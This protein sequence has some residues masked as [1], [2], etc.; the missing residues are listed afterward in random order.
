G[1]D[2]GVAGSI[3]QDALQG[4]VVLG[5]RRDVM[6]SLLGQSPLHGLKQLAVDQWRLRARA[7]L[8]FIENLADVEAIAQEVEQGALRE[9]HAT[10]R[11]AVRQLADLCSPIALAK[12]E[13]QPVDAAE[14]EIATKDH[15]DPLGLLFDD[16]ELAILEFVSQRHLPPTH[17]PLRLEAA[18]LSRMRS[19]VT[20]RSNCANESNTFRVSRPIEVVVLNCWVTETP[21]AHRTTRRVWRSQPASGSG[22]RP[23][24]RR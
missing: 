16:G 1:R 24:R 9:G 23:C 6:G 17:S 2:H 15:A 10:A 19:A 14:R 21:R 8:T 3:E 12:V 13:H 7:D 11:A 4:S 5:P 18:T 20:S 22:G